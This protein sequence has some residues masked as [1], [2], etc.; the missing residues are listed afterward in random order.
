MFFVFGLGGKTKC[1]LFMD[2]FW[3]RENCQ[4]PLQVLVFL[5]SHCEVNIQ[6]LEPLLDRIHAD[7]HNVAIPIIDI[8]NSDTFQYEASPLVKGKEKNQ[9]HFLIIS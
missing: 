9:F 1:F 3:E 4:F 2:L 7:Y 8:I 5:D 6:W